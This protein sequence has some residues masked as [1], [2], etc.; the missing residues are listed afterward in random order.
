MA[1]PPKDF[2]CVNFKLKK[3][4][5]S[6]YAPFGNRF[7]HQCKLFWI[8]SKLKDIGFV[9]IEFGVNPQTKIGW[10]ITSDEF[11]FR[12][13]NSFLKFALGFYIDLKLMQSNNIKTENKFWIWEKG[14]EKLLTKNHEVVIQ[15]FSHL[16]R[17]VNSSPDIFIKM[18]MFHFISNILMNAS[19]Y[20]LLYIKMILF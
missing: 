10:R 16:R 14:C 6:Y 13:I 9:Q 4:Y 11:G 5:L 7:L 15:R 17:L 20:R 1:D 19:F 2:P 12:R 8:W 3:F 18:W